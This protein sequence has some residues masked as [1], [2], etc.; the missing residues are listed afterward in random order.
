MLRLT[1][2]LFII[3]ACGL[4]GFLKAENMKKRIDN[5]GKIISALTLLENEI[6]YGKR[7]IKKAMKSIGD[8]Q[9]LPLFIHAAEKMDQYSAGEALCN[10]LKTK[11][12]FLLGTDNEILE[13]MA[14]DLGKTDTRSQIKSIEYAKCRLES[15]KKTA[16]EE[17]IKSGRLYRS[18]GILV[19]TMAV[20]ILF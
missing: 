14:E 7:N 20:I 12:T 18:M 1:G 13:I 9:N 19:G 2:A 15:V 5:L 16:E 11:D 17:Y 8:I 3:S 6:T 10:A 4:W